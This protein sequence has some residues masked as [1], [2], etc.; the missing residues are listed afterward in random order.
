MHNSSWSMVD[1]TCFLTCAGGGERAGPGDTVHL[2]RSTGLSRVLAGVWNH[3][4]DA[5]QRSLLQLR[6]H[7]TEARQ[8]DDR[9]RQKSLPRARSSQL[10]VDK[11]DRQLRQCSS[12]LSRALPSGKTR[13]AY[14]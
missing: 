7:R 5:V 10:L 1:F 6:G 11:P 8:L 9:S 4:R 3:G 12:R 2:Q 13:R 14:T